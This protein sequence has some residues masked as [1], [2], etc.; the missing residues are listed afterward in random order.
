MCFSKENRTPLVRPYKVI[1]YY[2][3]LKGYQVIYVQGF[4]SFYSFNLTTSAF[5]KRVAHQ[6]YHVSNMMSP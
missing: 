6:V 5:I 1:A 4:K 3:T 2:S